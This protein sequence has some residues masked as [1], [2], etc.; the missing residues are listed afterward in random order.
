LR[1][2]PGE[3]DGRTRPDLFNTYLG[4]APSGPRYSWRVV[5]VLLMGLICLFS[6]LTCF[7]QS[8]ITGRVINGTTNLPAPNQKV[9]LLTLGEGMK[10]AAEAQTGS[11]GSF[12]FA[13]V[14]T[15]AQTPHLLLRVI[16][17]GVNYNLSVASHQEMDKPLTLTIYETTQKLDEIKVS[18]PVML[19][20]ASGNALYV[21]QQYL[22]EN[23]TAPK[24]TLVNPYATF[25][26]DTPPPKTINDLNVSVVGLAGIPLPQIPTPRKEGGYLITYPMKPGVNE[27][28]VSYQVKSTTNQRELRHRLFQGSEATQVLIMP[29]D[30]Q[31]RGEGLQPAG[32]DSRTQAAIYRVTSIAKGGFLDLKIVGDAP[33][34]SASDEHNHGGEGGE[35]QVRVVRLPNT[36]FQKKEVIL[37]AFAAFFVIAILY[38]LRQ[39]GKAV[40]KAKALKKGGR[41]P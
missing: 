36:V 5:P 23:N 1:R 40:Q 32:K 3:G 13:A 30:L 20:Q 2:L 27:V 39:R 19:A 18:L 17:Q 16:Y 12:T 28:R 6:P 38:A 41:K 11:D 31:V 25:L 37:G 34:V 7:A 10:T 14:E 9:E 33:E 29:P 26:F 15:T 8:T 24:K 21:H 35:D 4:T 22:V